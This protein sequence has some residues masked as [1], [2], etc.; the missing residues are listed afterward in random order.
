MTVG[1]A[2]TAV[3]TGAASGIGFALS[4][5]LGERGCRLMMSDVEKPALEEAVATLSSGGVEAVG[6]TCDVTKLDEVRSLEESARRQLGDIDA[7]F[8]NAGIFGGLAPMWELDILDWRWTIDVD[9]YGVIHG[10]MAFVPAMVERNAG[11][12]NATASLAGVSS[13]PFNA[14]YNAAKHGVV[15]LME[16]LRGEL[17]VLAP[18]VGVSVTCPG[19]V[20]TRIQQ[21][22]RNRPAELTS[23]NSKAAFLDFTGV[24]SEKDELII[25][26]ATGISGSASAEDQAI[27]AQF[28]DPYPFAGEVL[29]QIDMGRLHVAPGRAVARAAA[30]RVDA[31]MTDLRD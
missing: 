3:V 27:D 16:T 24:L 13:P 31:L 10:I 20:A 14:A 28:L 29:R 25:G 8:L 15:A 23:P 21:S 4:Q 5:H 2:R 9:L 12:V 1:K 19:G 22:V 6:V 18:K 26:A 30:A 7:V 17:D 11:H